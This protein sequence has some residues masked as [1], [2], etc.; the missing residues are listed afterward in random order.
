VLHFFLQILLEMKSSIFWDIATC[1][2][3]EVNWR[4]GGI[5]LL[6]LQCWRI[7]M[8]YVAS[9][10]VASY[11]L[12]AW[13]ILQPWRWRRNVPP[14]GRFTS[15]WLQGTIS[16]LWEPHILRLFQIFGA[17]LIFNDLR[18]RWAQ[19]CTWVCMRRVSY[20]S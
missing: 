4:F 20:R 6:H 9:R 2:Q 11:L 19:K 10:A 7:N 1:S 5:C 13:L 14:K 12:H 18:S 15:N 17:P 8:K 16:P 3:L